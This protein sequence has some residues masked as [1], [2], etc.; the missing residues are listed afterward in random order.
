MTTGTIT[1][2]P[3]K[4]T[5]KKNRSLFYRISAWL[6]LWLGLITGIVVVIVSLTGAV[7]VF[8]QEL[9]VMC[10]SFQTAPANNRLML[11]PSVLKD[12]AMK[13]YNLPSVSAIVYQGKDRCAV[14]PYYADR[15]NML[16]NYIDPYTGKALRSKPLEADFFRVMLRGH[17]NLWLPVE[18]GKPVVAY[19]TLIFVITLITGL[20]LWWPKKWSKATR[21]QSFRI[22]WGATTKRLNYDLHNVLGFYS[23]IIGLILA[24]TGM[25]YG[26]KWLSDS[27]YFTA[28]GGK[29]HTFERGMNK[30]DTTLLKT[31]PVP[32]EDLLFNQLKAAGKDLDNEILVIGYPRGKA[33]A[34]NVSFATA[35]GK[36]NYE[37]TS[38]E[39]ISLKP[40]KK[41][42][43]NGG[44]RF[45]RLNYDLHLGSVGGI[46]TKIIA[47]LACLICAS[48]PITGF[49]IWWGKK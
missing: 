39:Q 12:A 38:Y 41:K 7:L 4:K 18:I 29:K 28:S 13:A 21:K 8:E 37:N 49:I 20:V 1:A 36:S 22:K 30:S 25:V 47:F 19:S 48:L 10:Q 45:M 14:V 9:R 34:W 43:E 26:M 17:Y 23:L 5:K 24:L 35:L 15:K 27:V 46:S 42:A 6:H 32:D 40:M 2:R 11:P 33:G 44:D 3:A 31:S 16:L